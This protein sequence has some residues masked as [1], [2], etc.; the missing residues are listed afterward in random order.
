MSCQYTNLALYGV[1]QDELV[2]YLSMIGKD[3]YVSP[4]QNQFTVM[5]DSS[6]DISPGS[7]EDNSDLAQLNHKATQMIE[8]TTQPYLRAMA[9]LYRLAIAQSQP[10]VAKLK[11][12]DKHSSEILKQYGGTTEGVLA[13]WASHLSRKFC[14]PAFTTYLRDDSQFWYH[15]SLNGV[16]TDEYTTYALNDW[17]PGQGI[18]SELGNKIKGGNAKT[19]CSTYHTEEKTNEVEIILRKPCISS[20]NHE[21]TS[22]I[23]YEIL[24]GLSS[25]P[26]EILR[27]Q[28]LVLALGMPACWTLYMSYS[29]ITQGEAEDYLDDYVVHNSSIENSLSML[30]QAQPSN[31]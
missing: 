10:I 24:L 7:F 26:N 16:M 31:I 21:F 6:F 3:S 2:E 13:C 17:Q 5:Y 9:E 29:A 8:H 1:D 30:K 12:L 25:F 11:A 14:C 18:Q 19:L 20:S 15:L 22:E 27:H 28:A 23:N 4:T